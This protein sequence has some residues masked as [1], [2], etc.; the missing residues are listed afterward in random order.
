MYSYQSHFTQMNY[1]NGEM[2]SDNPWEVNI[3]LVFEATPLKH[4]YYIKC[5]VL[6]CK[7]FVLP[8][9]NFRG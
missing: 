5:F 3:I 1:R 6:Q 8:T 4:N 9:Y 7:V 2:K